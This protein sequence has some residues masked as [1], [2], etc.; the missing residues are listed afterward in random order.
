[1]SVSEPIHSFIN[2]RHHTPQY[3]EKSFK[4]FKHW[5]KSPLTVNPNFRIQVIFEHESGN[6]TKEFKAGDLSEPSFHALAARTFQMAFSNEDPDQYNATFKCRI[7]EKHESR[8]INFENT[9]GL[10]FAIQS[11]DDKRYAFISVS[12][13]QKGAACP[14]ISIV[15]SSL[16]V[17]TKRKVAKK[18]KRTK[19]RGTTGNPKMSVKFQAKAGE[20]LVINTLD[21]TRQLLENYSQP[22]P[23]EEDCAV[24][25]WMER[26]ETLHS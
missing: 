14:V 12:F 7:E 9:E 8:W 1:M 4:Q 25:Y 24:S 20:V 11:N 17:T 18:T 16:Q 2:F 6:P 21:S 22:T 10:G 5:S 15:S 26:C 19:H 13:I 23:L 3:C